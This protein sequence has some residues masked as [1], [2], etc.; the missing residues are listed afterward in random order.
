MKDDDLDDT[1]MMRNNTTIILIMTITLIMIMLIHPNDIVI[2]TELGLLMGDILFKVIS[3]LT[4][5]L[6]IDIR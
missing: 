2:M 3:M 5:T 6:T 1:T 4:K